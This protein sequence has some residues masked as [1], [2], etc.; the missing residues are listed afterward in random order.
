MENTEKFWI[1]YMLLFSLNYWIAEKITTTNKRNAT[2]LIQIIYFKNTLTQKFKPK[3]KL[4]GKRISNFVSTENEK[5][6]IS[7][8]LICL[9]KPDP[10][11]HCPR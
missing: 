6:W 11:K 2:G 3:D 10:L 4:L 7:S 5:L 8:K 9:I 1:L